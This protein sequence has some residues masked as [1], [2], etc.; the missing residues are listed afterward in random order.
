MTD[1]PQADALTLARQAL[2]ARPAALFVDFD[3]TLSPI[4]LDPTGARLVPGAAEALR[5]LAGQFA[6]VC[7]VTGRAA[8]DVR[9]MTGLVEVWIAGNHGIEW[10][11]PGESQ[12]ERP[13][14]LAGNRAELERLLALV[15]PIAG[16]WVEDKGLS[17]AVHYRGTPDPAA[18]RAQVLAALSAAVSGTA[19]EL[20]EGRMSVELRPMGL[21]DKGSAVRAL[22]E[23][24]A[25]RGLLVLGDDVTDLDMFRAAAELREG[26][27]AATVIAVGGHGEVPARVAEAADVVVADPKAAVVLLAALAAGA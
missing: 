9:R 6:V 22:A 27:A 15:P 20:R 19:I 26:G 23:R 7:I 3:G 25:L 24:F 17:A 12:V 16:V 4:V 2:S 10:L 18:A 11:A 13:P 14:A 5:A 8:S 1:A 21:G